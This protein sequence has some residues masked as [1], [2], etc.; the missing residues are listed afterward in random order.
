MQGKAGISGFSG[1]GHA[2]GPDRSM[3]S[4]EAGFYLETL[5]LTDEE[6][7]D[8][9]KD[10]IECG[11]IKFSKFRQ[12]ISRHDNKAIDLQKQMSRIYAYLR[13]KTSTLNNMADAMR[14]LSRRR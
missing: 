11:Y 2:A 7:L 1:H 6:I 12:T 5:G 13:V 4:Y 14:I 8:L 3:D 9:L 10:D